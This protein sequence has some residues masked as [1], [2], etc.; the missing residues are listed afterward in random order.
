MFEMW[1]GSLDDELKKASEAE[2]KEIRMLRK[3]FED[4]RKSGANKDK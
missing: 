4:L 3:S 2:T 1:P